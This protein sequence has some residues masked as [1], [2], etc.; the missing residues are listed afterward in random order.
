MS[1]T[2]CE[3]VGALWLFGG[4]QQMHSW[5]RRRQGNTLFP[6]YLENALLYMTTVVDA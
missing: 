6:L 1:T 3:H 5:R 2:S 4:R